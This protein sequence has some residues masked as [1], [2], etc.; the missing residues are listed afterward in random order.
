M[1]TYE[2]L[3]SKPLEIHQTSKKNRRRKVRIL[4]ACMAFLLFNIL[5]ALSLWFHLYHFFRTVFVVYLT[6]VLLFPALF[7]A[8]VILNQR[9]ACSRRLDRS[10]IGLICV[11]VLLC[12]VFVYA[13][14]IEPYRLQVETIDLVSDKVTSPFT[15]L[16][17]SDI[18]SGAVG[19]YE[20]NVFAR[21]QQLQPDLIIHTGDLLHPFMYKDLS[22]E[23]TKIAQLFR[24]LDP[25]YGIY[26][27]IGDV[28]RHIE[29]QV[30]EQAAG[31]V[32]L[33]DEDR[34]IVMQGAAV[35]LLGLSRS[36]SRRGNRPLIE[37]WHRQYDDALT[38]VF[39]HA[40]DYVL[41][42]LHLDIDLCLAGHTHGG[43]IRIPFIGPLVTLSRI[44]KEWAMG[45]RTVNNLRINV[46]AGIGAEHSGQLPPIRVNCPPTMT[47][48]TIR[49]PS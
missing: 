38:I 46:S 48:F 5:A 20:R 29:P 49:P 15:L 17:L 40:P 42:I 8:V 13:S 10:E 7:V 4:I 19:R 9:T 6:N 36:S 30:F 28:D 43:Q 41:E 1:E 26:N 21:I 14:L 35:R 34:R 31:V 16:H 33:Q 44:P 39:G 18:Q 23:K 47:L 2:L 27:V 25:P 24:T 37:Q 12:G 11:A 32:T 3:S 22:R 45:Y